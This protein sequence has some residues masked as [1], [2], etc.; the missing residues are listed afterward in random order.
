MHILRLV[1]GAAVVLMIAGCQG[2]EIAGPTAPGLTAEAGASA[3]ASRP[4]ETS[5][6]F[7]AIVDFSTIT[8]KERGSNCVLD[9]QGRL[10]LHGTI[11][12]VATGHTT[13]LVFATCAAVASAP[14]GTYPDVF[15]SELVFSGTVAGRAARANVIY[16]GRSERGG[17]ISAHL[18]FS[19]GVSGVL[20]VEAQLAVGGS[21]QGSLVVH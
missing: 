12:G 10:E 21:Y 1:S 16:K 2:R 3:S 18:I 6:R 5:G 20:D 7:D 11:E 15:K 17:H 8:F 14:P 19:R 9:V 4:V 13:A